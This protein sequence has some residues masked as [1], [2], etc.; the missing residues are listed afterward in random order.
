MERISPLI[1]FLP[2]GF[3]IPQKSATIAMA[4]VSVFVLLYLLSSIFW[5]TLFSSGFLCGAHALF[6]DA[7][8]HKDMDDAVAM[9]GDL[10]VGEDA[11]FLN[12]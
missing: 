9:E 12:A 11:A 4:G 2:T 7:S 6:R 10:L 8:M 5:W 1:S 3:S